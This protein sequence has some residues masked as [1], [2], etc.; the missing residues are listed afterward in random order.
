MFR[1][2]FLFLAFAFPLSAFAADYLPPSGVTLVA[3]L[4]AHSFVDNV[5]ITG[6][7]GSILAVAFG[8]FMVFSAIATLRWMFSLIF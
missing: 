3:T 1:L 8:L 4:H 2:I 5:D 6:A 7:M